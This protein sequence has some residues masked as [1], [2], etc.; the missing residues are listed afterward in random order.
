M[1]TNKEQVKKNG[2]PLSKDG[3]RL[4]PSLANMT[5]QELIEEIL[6]THDWGYLLEYG[7][8]VKVSA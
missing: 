7:M 2:V 8:V 4:G 5:K 1:K 6:G 3:Y